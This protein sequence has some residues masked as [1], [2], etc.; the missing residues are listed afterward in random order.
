MSQLNYLAVLGRQAELGLVELESLLGSDGIQPFGRHAALVGQELKVARLGGVIKFGQIIYR[1]NWDG[2]LELP[3]EP[4]QLVE[5][6]AGKLQVAVSA[7]AKSIDSKR[8]KAIGMTIKKRLQSKYS[9]R[10]VVPKT[11]TSLS[12]AE[13]KYN[14]VLE[15][16]FEL[17]VVTNER[18]LVIAKTLEVQDVDWYS[19]RDYGRPARDTSVGMMP[20]KL[21][22]VLVNTTHSETVVDPF[23]GT[24]L[25]LQEALLL[26]REAI[27]S[28]TSK[29]MVRAANQNLTWLEG[30]VKIR[31][32]KW[33][34][35]EADA[36]QVKI[37]KDCAVVSEG[38]LGPNL[39]RSPG[40]PELAKLERDMKE[41]YA[42]FLKNLARQ[43]ADG[44]EMAI[45]VPA[46]RKD[47]SWRETGLVDELPRLGY[48]LRGFQHVRSPLLYS[49]EGQVVGRQILLLR[50][51]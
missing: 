44:A 49:R 36:R 10:L 37:P 47:G 4:E 32:P 43:L 3:V 33:R 51:N 24:G 38:Y 31:L 2:G 7:T 39:S 15:H 17:V 42:Q 22:Q 5:G 18:E 35:E 28:D 12:A 6:V 19:R 8:L 40:E 21:A 14:G 26:G 25:I 1:G 34:I 20:P 16:G 11:G 13:L 29:K 27:G 41:L 45:C 46:W 50:K 48:S 23:C 30:E 9:V